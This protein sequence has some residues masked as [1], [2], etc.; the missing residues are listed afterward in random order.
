MSPFMKFALR[1]AVIAALVLSAFF[2]ARDIVLLHEA[3]A[4]V[5]ALL[6][7]ISVNGERIRASWALATLLIQAL[8]VFVVTVAATSLASA[9]ALG[10]MLVSILA[11][12]G[13]LGCYRAV[14]PLGP[15][16]LDHS[17]RRH[18]SPRF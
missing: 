6:A 3:S 9:L 15:V 8:G 12:V 5:A 17:T 13:I 7:V 2:A 14:I 16:R 10:L 11:L 1:L 4:L 18:F